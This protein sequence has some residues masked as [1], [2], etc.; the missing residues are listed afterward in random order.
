MTI[1]YAKKPVGQH[2]IEK[3]SGEQLTGPDKSLENKSKAKRLSLR[4]EWR[5]SLHTLSGCRCQQM[6]DTNIQIVMH[7]Q[8][9]KVYSQKLWPWL[10]SWYKTKDLTVT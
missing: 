9:V 10:R 2:S 7:G 1:I 8:Q 5:S 6:M 3:S 4:I